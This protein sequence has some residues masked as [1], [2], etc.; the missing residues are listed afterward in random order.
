MHQNGDVNY[1]YLISGLDYWS[2]LPSGINDQPAIIVK[3]WN[4]LIIGVVYLLRMSFVDLS[5]TQDVLTNSELYL[6][7]VTLT[8]FFVFI[9]TLFQFLIFTYEVTKNKTLWSLAVLSF[10]F[11]SVIFLNI[12]SNKPE[13]YLVIA[14]LWLGSII[15]RLAQNKTVAS[16]KIVCCIL[17]AILSKITIAPFLIP[18]LFLI[19][20][21]QLFRAVLPFG[22]VSLIII[23]IAWS[24]ELNPFL[25]W[26]VNVG[27]HT[28]SYGAGEVGLYG[29]DL[30]S[31]LLKLLRI[32]GLPIITL[33]LGLTYSLVKK[34]N[35]I[36]V[37]SI[38]VSFFIF[39][40]LILKM[41]SSNYFVVSYA[42]LPVFILLAFEGINLVWNT[43]LMVPLVLL[44]ILVRLTLYS[45][46]M[47]QFAL[48]AQSIESPTGVQTYYSSSPSYALFMANKT[49]FSR[50]SEALSRIYPN[51]TFYWFDHT[52]CNFKE[53]ISHTNLRGK[54][55]LISG[56]SD[57]VE[58][59]S[60][61]NIV[62]RKI[63]GIKYIYKVKVK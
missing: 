10:F 12:W 53:R 11:S 63:D 43:K 7:V 42:I 6:H 8:I 61:L 23:W 27:S 48:V 34:V 16:W 56:T 20:S 60:L 49:Q 35:R 3:L 9:F 52:F 15:L 39:F 14:G 47:R 36:A 1:T 32:N 40:M 46:S 21:K 30:S 54:I 38:C 37:I 22:I 51:D 59:D 57:N 19:P 25:Q 55:I 58:S 44:F 26:I 2:L 28:G 33:V 50:H 45:R 5:M 41:P 18:L 24:R 17:F 13:P 31:N 4:A 62:S 29:A